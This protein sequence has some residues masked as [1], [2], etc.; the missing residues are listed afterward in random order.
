MLKT[1]GYTLIQLEL[2]SDIS[3]YM[4]DTY[5]SKYLEGLKWFLLGMTEAVR[6]PDMVD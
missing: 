1:R 5:G 4:T 3:K 2:P 6:T